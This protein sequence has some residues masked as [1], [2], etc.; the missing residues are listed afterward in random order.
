VDAGV[1]SAC[2]LFGREATDLAQRERDL[3][4]GR[5][6]RVTAGED[7]PEA[8]VLDALVVQLERRTDAVAKPVGHLGHRRIEARPAAQRV[9]RLETAGGHQP[10]P[11]IPGN[12]VRRPV[13]HGRRERLL[14]RLFRQIEV[15]Q[16]A[17]EGGEDSAGLGAKDFFYD[18][19]PY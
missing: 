11:G 1:R 13:L 16:E 12:S 19:A 6:G 3:R 9:D 17:N 7:E 14:E 2:D 18:I 10:G 5:Q 15:T 8:I 4:I